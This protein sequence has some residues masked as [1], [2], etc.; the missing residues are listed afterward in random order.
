MKGL[1]N[2]QVE[3]QFLMKMDVLLLCSRA[4]NF[5][6]Q[7]EITLHRAKSDVQ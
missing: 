3:E 1:I 4:L 5:L 6:T 2:G 7:A